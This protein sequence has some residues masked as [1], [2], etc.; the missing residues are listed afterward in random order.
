[1][2]TELASKSESAKHPR[3]LKLRHASPFSQRVHQAYNGVARR[4]YELYESRGFWGVWPTV[5]GRVL[6][7][8]EAV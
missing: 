6:E 7:G 3:V 1:M 4:T 5:I 2:T 8:A